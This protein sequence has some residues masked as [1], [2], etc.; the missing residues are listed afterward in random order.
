MREFESSCAADFTTTTVKD[1][2]DACNAK[3]TTV[4]YMQHKNPN[5]IGRHL[6]SNCYRHYYKKEGTVHWSATQI[7]HTFGT[8]HR[9]CGQVIHKQIAE[10]Q[11]GR[12]C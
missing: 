8:E 6:C 3:A 7:T 11:R 5:K 10:A 2:C 1:T 4:K 12:M 9:N